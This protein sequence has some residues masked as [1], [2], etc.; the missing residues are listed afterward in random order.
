MAFHPAARRDGI[1]LLLARLRRVKVAR[2]AISTDIARQADARR[3][4]RAHPRRQ[5]VTRKSAAP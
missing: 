4:R 3:G 2:K 5:D 1:W